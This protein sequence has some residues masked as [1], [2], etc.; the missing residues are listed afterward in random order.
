MPI[1]SPIKK[2]TC[3]IKLAVP[4]ARRKLYWNK[5]VTA[6]VTA[7]V[8]WENLVRNALNENKFWK[9]T[10]KKSAVWQ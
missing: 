9:R 8:S 3:Q 1:K 10:F 7:K 2:E 4:T 5:R 6:K